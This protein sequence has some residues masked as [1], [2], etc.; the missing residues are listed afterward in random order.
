MRRIVT[1]LQTLRGAER[2]GSPEID[3]STEQFGGSNTNFGEPSLGG[4]DQEAGSRV[5]SYRKSTIC[6]NG[7]CEI[8]TCTNAQC[9]TEM[10]KNY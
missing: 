4:N 10:K 3:D 1:L 8:K 7:Q 6:I 2:E 5:F 9:T